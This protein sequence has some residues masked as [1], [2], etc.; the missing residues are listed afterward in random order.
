MRISGKECV[1]VYSPQIVGEM[2]VALRSSWDVLCSYH[3]PL[4]SESRRDQTREMLARRLL[5]CAATGETNKGRLVTY[6]L[7]SFADDRVS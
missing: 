1:E 3:S 2:R 5:K 6:A 4:A 7:G